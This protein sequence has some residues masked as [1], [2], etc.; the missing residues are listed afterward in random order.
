MN[1]GIFGVDRTFEVCPGKDSYT[2][3]QVSLKIRIRQA[4]AIQ[5]LLPRCFE[6]SFQVISAGKPFQIDQVVR[7]SVPQGN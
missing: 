6:D 4:R 7:R 2:K 1:S 3:Y 5:S